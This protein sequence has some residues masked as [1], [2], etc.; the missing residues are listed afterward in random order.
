MMGWKDCSTSPSTRS[1]LLWPS[2]PSSALC[3]EPGGAS[4]GEAEG[5]AITFNQRNEKQQKSDVLWIKLEQKTKNNPSCMNPSCA[6]GC[7]SRHS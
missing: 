4:P 7:S 3:Q 6:T 1:S 5:E 2:P